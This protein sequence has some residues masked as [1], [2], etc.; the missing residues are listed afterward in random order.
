MLFNCVISGALDTGYSSPKLP[1]LPLLSCQG[2]SLQ[3][4]TSKV[5]HSVHPEPK[6]HLPCLQIKHENVL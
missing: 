6:H 5:L 4:Q 3:K 1:D 2:I